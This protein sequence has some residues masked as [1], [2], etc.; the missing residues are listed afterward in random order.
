[1]LENYL[2]Y[3]TLFSFYCYVGAVPI[4]DCTSDIIDGYRYRGAQSAG[5]YGIQTVQRCMDKCDINANCMGWSYEVDTKL[6]WFHSTITGITAAAN[7]KSGSCIGKSFTITE[8][9]AFLFF[10]Y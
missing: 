2:I 4:G 10:P 9:Y 8:S 7:V 3:Q 5:S 1:M 6:C